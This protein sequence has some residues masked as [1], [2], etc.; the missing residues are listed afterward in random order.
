MDKVKTTKS[1][2]SND[3]YDK[4]NVN[5][6]ALWKF[7][8]KADGENSWKTSFG[9]GRPGWHIECSAMSMKI[10]GNSL[11]IHTGAS[12][13]IFPHHTNEIAQSEAYSGKKFVNY[14]LHGGFLNMKE[15]KMS[16]SLGNIINPQD[17]LKNYKT[18]ESRTDSQRRYLSADKEFR[19]WRHTTVR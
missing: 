7:T 2:I 8:T 11:D 17:L 5:D 6:F 4:N 3:E 12:D 9:K 19:K 10:L 14:W 18:S 13:L 1:R 15:G 16:K